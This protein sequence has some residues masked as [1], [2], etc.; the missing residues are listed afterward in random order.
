MTAL[1]PAPNVDKGLLLVVQ[2]VRELVCLMKLLVDQQV[3][4]KKLYKVIQRAELKLTEADTE[5]CL[6]QPLPV[7]FMLCFVDL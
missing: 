1:L 2:L 7:L 4:E 5:T 3:P 6:L